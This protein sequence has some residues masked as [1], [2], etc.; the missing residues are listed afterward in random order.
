MRSSWAA[1][2]GLIVAVI[3]VGMVPM[4]R[5][6]GEDEKAVVKAPTTS[7]AATTE[8]NAITVIVGFN[9]IVVDQ[10]PTDWNTVRKQLAAIPAQRRRTMRLNLAAGSADLPVGKYFEAQAEGVRVVQELGLAYLSNTGIAPSGDSSHVDADQFDVANSIAFPKV[11]SPSLTVVPRLR[12]VLDPPK[13]SGWGETLVVRRTTS[14]D[15]E[16][17]LLGRP[18]TPVERFLLNNFGHTS[19][20][21]LN[22][23]MK[24]EPTTRP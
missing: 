17:G 10:Q 3:A 8:P 18:L 15:M 13:L 24:I 14:E 2:V 11:V 16:A 21:K 23:A 5:S 7:P 22:E 6:F 12:A 9:A 1:I 4:S 19:V 20:T